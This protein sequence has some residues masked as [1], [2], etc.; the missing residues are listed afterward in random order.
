VT[1]I[2]VF[3]PEEFHGAEIGGLPPALMGITCMLE[4]S[5]H[6]FDIVDSAGDL[7]R[8]QVVVLPD[9]IP[10]SAELA[11]KLQAYL[12]G[13]GALLASFESGMNGAKTAFTLKASGVRFKSEGPRDLKGELVRGEIYE[14]ADYVSSTH[15]PR[16]RWG[17]GWPRP[18]TRCMYEAWTWRLNQGRRC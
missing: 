7:T 3:T 16:G 18:N 1:E 4:E 13:G 14:C 6:Q 8:Y 11:G 12:D 17:Q 9:A 2:G 5:A 10:V 15:Y